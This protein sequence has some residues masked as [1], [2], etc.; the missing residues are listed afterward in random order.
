MIAVLA[1]GFLFVAAV[2]VFFLPNWAIRRWQSD[3]RNDRTE[4]R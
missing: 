4:Q 2:V 3:R 1:A